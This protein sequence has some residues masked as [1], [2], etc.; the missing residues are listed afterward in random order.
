MKKMLFVKNGRRGHPGA[1]ADMLREWNVGFEIV[2]I[3]AGENF[4][5]PQ[6]YDALV[7]L[8]G[9]DSANDE[10]AKIRSALDF[11]RQALEIEV[12]YLG[13]CLGMQILVKAAGGEVIKAAQPEVGFYATADE[14]Y[15]IKLTE[16]GQGEPLLADLPTTMPVFQQ[17]RDTVRLTDSMTLLAAGWPCHNQIVKIG[18]KA[19]GVQPH[20]ELTPEMLGMWAVDDPHLVPIGQ[21]KLAHD[22]NGIAD[23]YA[24]TA[25]TLFGNFLNVTDIT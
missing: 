21:E 13:I 25:R 16:A 6:N 5:L 11:V 24:A 14:R 19:Y 22:L 8:G 20:I 18:D 3:Y 9:P 7:V 4:P 15:Q 17:H 23:I 12:P 2:D 10:T 1:L